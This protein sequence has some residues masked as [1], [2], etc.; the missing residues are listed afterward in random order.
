MAPLVPVGSDDCW[1][2]FKTLPNV[3][4]ED[5]VK[6]LS[7]VAPRVVTDSKV[8]FSVKLA[9]IVGVWPWLMVMFGP[10]TKPYKMFGAVKLPVKTPAPLTVRSPLTL[11]LELISKNLSTS[12]SAK[13]SPFK[14]E[15]AWVLKAILEVLLSPTFWAAD[16]DRVLMVLMAKLLNGLSKLPAKVKLAADGLVLSVY[17]VVPKN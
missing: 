11:V 7:V 9:E 5:R 3:T 13:T 12:D 17:K 10:A 15:G 2:R 8:S 14:V 6:A 16:G 1:P 4:A